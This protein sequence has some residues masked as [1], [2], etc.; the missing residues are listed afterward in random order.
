MCDPSWAQVGSRSA[1]GQSAATH[2]LLSSLSY[3]LGAGGTRLE[4]PWALGKLVVTGFCHA[5]LQ[6]M[7]WS[8]RNGRCPSGFHLPAASRAMSIL[9][10]PLHIL[11]QMRS[12][13]QHPGIF[14]AQCLQLEC[15]PNQTQWIGCPKNTGK[16]WKSQRLPKWINTL[17]KPT[18]FATRRITSGENVPQRISSIVMRRKSLKWHQI[19]DIHQF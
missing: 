8:P 19:F 5:S 7:P 12:N 1:L 4:Y 3:S 15:F 2:P 11:V 17:Q 9:T 13:E 16:H 10:K 18:A 14:S 6:G